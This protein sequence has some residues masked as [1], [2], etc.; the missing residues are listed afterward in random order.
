MDISYWQT[1][2]KHD[3]VYFNCF[4]KIH[5]ISVIIHQC[6]I[7]FINPDK[8]LSHLFG[9]MEKKEFHLNEINR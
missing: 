6:I 8:A 2:M 7:N 3:T 4:Y 9:I 1:I 5:K